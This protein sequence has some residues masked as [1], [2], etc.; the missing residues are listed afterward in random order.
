MWQTESMAANSA[1]AVFENAKNEAQRENEESRYKSKLEKGAD[2]SIAQKELV[3]N[4][5]DLLYK[6]NR[7]LSD[8]YDKLK[9][10]YDAQCQSTIE[11]KEDLRRSRR[12]NAWMMVVSII[13]MLA[14]IAS[15]VISMVV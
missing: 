2:A 12:Y 15:I 4:Q 8:N 7:L 11:A 5:V 6:Q 13:S 9:E 3:K 14:A 10:I 1:R